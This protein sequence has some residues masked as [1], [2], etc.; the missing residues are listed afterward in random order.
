MALS[1]EEH[2][3]RAQVATAKRSTSLSGEEREL[4]KEVAGIE[5]QFRT[6]LERARAALDDC[7]VDTRLMRNVLESRRGIKGVFNRIAESGLSRILGSSVAGAALGTTSRRL[8]HASNPVAGAITGGALGGFWGWMRGRNRVESATNWMNQLNM[9]S[10]TKE[11]DKRSDEELEMMLGIMKQAVEN[12]K[13]RGSAASKL[14]MARNYRAV[15]NTLAKRRTEAATDTSKNSAVLERLNTAIGSESDVGKI[16]SNNCGEQYKELYEQVLKGNRKQ[17]WG[18]ALKGAAVGAG[19][20][21]LGGWL[22]DKVFHGTASGGNTET[23]SGQSII[24]AKQETLRQQHENVMNVYNNQELASNSELQQYLPQIEHLNNLSGLHGANSLQGFNASQLQGFNAMLGGNESISHLVQQAGLHNIDLGARVGETGQTLANFL[25]QNKDAYLHLAPEVQRQILSYPS[26]AQEIINASTSTGAIATSSI[27]GMTTAVGGAAGVAAIGGAGLYY[28]SKGRTENQV[29]WSG[30]R[31]SAKEE[32]KTYTEAAKEKVKQNTEASK[33]SLIGSELYFLDIAKIDGG[34]PKQTTNRKFKVIDVDA[35]GKLQFELTTNDEAELRKPANKRKQFH[36]NVNIKDIVD[37][38]GKLDGTKLAIVSMASA[39]S[40]ASTSGEKT[41]D[42]IKT[43]LTGKRLNVLVLDANRLQLPDYDEP[44]AYDIGRTK[45]ALPYPS[46]R[47]IVNS[48]KEEGGAPKLSVDF[49]EDA[50]GQTYL[51][52]NSIRKDEANFSAAVG[53][54]GVLV[55]NAG[56]LYIAESKTGADVSL[57]PVL[58]G[59]G[60]VANVTLNMT[61]L[62]DPAF[63]W[64]KEKV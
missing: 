31:E 63:M 61:Q 58:A 19:L 43:E 1:P 22:F 13:V 54:A 7:D 8:L 56:T 59:A 45:Q 10:N 47:I 48:V 29:A 41:F 33:Q 2:W 36:P 62:K 37:N 20:G 27:I 24:A 25:V 52:Q 21:A 57:R 28:G 49:Y 44:I 64:Y 39:E 40:G 12:G 3:V 15:K 18:S 38:D 17:I 26:L 32:R 30:A 23:Y 4:A 5:K 51:Y 14:E 55:R 50:E 60:S 11:L 34:Y 42:E 16:I 35:D 53:A 9:P 6:S 46:A